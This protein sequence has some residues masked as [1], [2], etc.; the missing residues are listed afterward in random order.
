MRADCLQLSCPMSAV[1]I[2]T[3][4]LREISKPAKELLVSVSAMAPQIQMQLCLATPHA[5]A[6]LCKSMLDRQELRQETIHCR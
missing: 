6:Q 2:S 4:F 5:S 1:A 3:M